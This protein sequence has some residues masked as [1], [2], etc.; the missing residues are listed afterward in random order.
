MKKFLSL[1]SF[2]TAYPHLLRKLDT[3]INPPIT[4]KYSSNIVVP[5]KMQDASLADR[6]LEKKKQKHRQFILGKKK[7]KEILQVVKLYPIDS[8][9]K[10]LYPN[11]RVYKKRNKLTSKFTGEEVLVFVKYENKKYTCFDEDENEWT[12]VV[13]IN[14]MIGAYK[15][16]SAIRGKMCEDGTMFWRLVSIKLLKRRK[17]IE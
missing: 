12:D 2:K 3:A 14:N 7:V 15:N 10:R 16:K 5:I 4:K 1:A 11:E 6:F 8:W 13:S 9:L 17:I